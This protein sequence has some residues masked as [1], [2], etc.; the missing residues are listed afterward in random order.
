MLTHLDIQEGHLVENGSECARVLIYLN[1]DEQERKHLVNEYGIDEHTLASALDPHEL[2][3][4]EFEQNHMALI[5]KRP[6]RYQSEDN[7]MFWTTSMG[8][9]L[10]SDRLVCVMSD[11]SPLIEGRRRGVSSLPEILLKAIY[12]SIFHFEEH[13]RIINMISDDI[14]DKIRRSLENRHL[15]SMFSIE[16][17]LVYYINA[18]SSNGRVIDKLRVNACKLGFTEEQLEFLEDIAI[19]NSQALEQARVYSHVLSGLM[20][21]RASIISNNLNAIMKTLTLVTIGIMLPNLVVSIFSMNLQMP[22]PHDSAWGFWIALLLAFG[23]V[24]LLLWI[25]RIKRWYQ[26]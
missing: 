19:E 23:T 4:L 7:F 21:A 6:K 20:D 8:L 17:S 11:D 16:K 14:E 22:I 3:R 2:A 18:I 9:F 24:G 5:L 10:F 1:P 15:L 25:G 13:L 12:S 26:S